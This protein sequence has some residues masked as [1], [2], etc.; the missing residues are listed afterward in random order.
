MVVMIKLSD[1]IDSMEFQPDESTAFLNRE[2]GEVATISDEAFQA[3]EN[4]EP[5][6][7]FPKQQQDAIKAAGKILESED[8]IP[9]PTKFDIHEYAIM[10][11]YCLSIPDDKLS[12]K[13]YQSIKSRSG[14]L[15]RFNDN[16]YRHDLA[17][18]WF[19]YR[20]LEIKEM[21]IEWCEENG[22][23]YKDE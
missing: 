15:R 21:A 6:D 12:D 9:L 4:N 7:D 1:I 20:R 5:L 11:R 22:L 13:L 16:I 14:A 18:K 17:E 3:V 2:T 23:S 19:R 10:E 8:Y